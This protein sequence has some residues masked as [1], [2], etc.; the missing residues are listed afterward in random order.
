MEDIQLST[1]QEKSETKR[2]F[3]LGETKV[4]CNDSNKEKSSREGPSAI[5]DLLST[6]SM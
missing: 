5:F 1:N 3:T 2:G 4:A 6:R